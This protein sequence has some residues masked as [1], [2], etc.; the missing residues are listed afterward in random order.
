MSRHQLVPTAVPALRDRD[1]QTLSLNTPVVAMDP[2]EEFIHQAL[3][4]CYLIKQWL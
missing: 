2:T 1:L 3:Q 4:P